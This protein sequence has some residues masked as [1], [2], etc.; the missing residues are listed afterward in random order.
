[1]NDGLG[2][3]KSKSLFLVLEG[4][5]L[6]IAVHWAFA[7]YFGLQLV[8]LN[9]NIP[10]S[11][12]GTFSS[13]LSP[14][15]ATVYMGLRLR[16]FP[17]IMIKPQTSLSAGIAI[18]LAWFVLLF[19]T[20]ALG[21]DDPFSR[22]ILKTRSQP[23]YFYLSIFVVVAWGPFL[24]EILNRGYFFGP[25]RTTWGDTA[26]LLISTFLFVTFHAIF[27]AIYYGGVGYELLFIFLHSIIFTASYIRGG[28]AAAILT[29]MFVNFYLLYLNM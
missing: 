21:Q 22:E 9:P 20:A 15:I 26:A 6:E 4:F 2:L 18:L 24:E 8:K 1:M 7:E 3:S 11:V 14:L 25:L 10:W 23:T 27:L 16:C 5:V 19:Q 17:V 12:A 13:T 29:H 28:M